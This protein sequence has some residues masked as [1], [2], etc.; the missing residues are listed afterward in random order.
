MKSTWT[1]ERERTL[2]DMWAR[3]C[4]TQEIADA[5]GFRSRGAVCG[6]INRHNI[7]REE[8]APKEVEM[9]GTLSVW[10]L[11]EDDR[12]A[13]FARI[14]AHGARKQLSALMAEVA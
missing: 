13:V 9:L 6:Y 11:P 4:G 8:L 1:P 12:R 5:L 2:R 10:D 7:T 3:G 14:A